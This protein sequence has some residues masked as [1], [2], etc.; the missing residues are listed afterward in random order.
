MLPG[1]MLSHLNVGPQIL[2]QTR[3]AG[4]SARPADATTLAILCVNFSLLYTA[5]I[6]ETRTLHLGIDH[7]ERDKSQQGSVVEHF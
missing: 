6:Q 1:N 4:S 2:L 3:C 5:A 7:G